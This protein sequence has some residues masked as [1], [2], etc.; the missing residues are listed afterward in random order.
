MTSKYLVGILFFVIL[1]GMSSSVTAASEI[2]NDGD[3]VPNSID[4]CPNL[5]EDYDPQY[6]DNIDGCP[7]DFVPWYDAD[8]DGIQ[9]HIDMC[10]TVQE[11]YNN[12]EDSDGCPDIVPGGTSRFIDSD[13]D[14]FADYLDKCPTLPETF[15]GIDDTDGCPDDTRTL[16]DRDIDGISDDMDSCVLE[17]ETYNGFQDT[18]GCPDS[19]T[20]DTYTAICIS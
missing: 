19:T 11:T 13:D 20:S 15:N 8:F 18:D 16:A 1:V 10:P 4:E 9:D 5:L 17:P 6:G 3:G 7:A 12:F 2:D 14:T